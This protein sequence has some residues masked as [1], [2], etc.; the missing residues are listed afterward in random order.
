MWLP[1][2]G[3]T[4]VQLD[5]K[6]TEEVTLTRM[7]VNKRRNTAIITEYSTFIDRVNQ[8]SSC[9]IRIAIN[10]KGFSNS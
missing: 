7:T 10:S 3:I 8:A 4:D 2:A 6:I 9:Q 1:L 5:A